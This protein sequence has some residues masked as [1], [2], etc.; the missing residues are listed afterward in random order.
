LWS[1]V[2]SRTAVRFEH[3][4]SG[5]AE[6]TSRTLEP[7]GIVSW[8]GRWYVVGR[9]RDREATRMFRMS[10]IGGNVKT[11]GSAGAFTVPE[12]TDLRSLVSELAPPRPT[13]EAKVRARTGSCVSLRRRANA[14]EPYEEG[15]DLLHVP[16]AD[17][18]VLAEEIASYGP[19]AVVEGPGDVLD[20]VLR[21]LRTVAGVL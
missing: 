14:I 9:D 12:G 11:V 1:A 10:R 3:R 4:R 19:D 17:S 5:A 7:W 13:S 8:H 21:R 15:W 18:G 6:T 16:Y 20:G 2:V